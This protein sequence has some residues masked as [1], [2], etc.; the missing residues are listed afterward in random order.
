MSK[1]A[2]AAGVLP[3]SVLRCAYG[4]VLASILSGCNWDLLPS[5]T[6]AVRTPGQTPP[7]FTS[8]NSVAVAEG[9]MTG[10]YTATANDAEGDT[11]SF[12]VSGGADGD[13]FSIDTGNGVVSFRSPPDFE[14]PSDDNGDNT[15]VVDLEVDD[16]RNGR[17]SLTLS[18]RVD[19]ANDAPVFTSGTNATTPENVAYRYVASAFDPDQDPLTFSIAGGA[20]QNAFSIDPATGFVEFAINPDFDLPA[21][22]NGD[23]VY[24][25][26][27]LADD[28]NGGTASRMLRVTVTDI[29]ELELTIGFPTRAANIGGIP[30]TRISGIVDDL[31]DG[32]VDADDLVAVE[33]NGEMAAVSAGSPVVWTHDIAAAVPADQ[34]MLRATPADGLGHLASLSLQNDAVIIRPDLLALDT[35]DNRLL[36]ADG[37]GL[38]ALVQ[39]DLGNN[40]KSVLLDGTTGNGP[41][42]LFPEAAVLDDATDELV[43]VDSVQ[44][45]II[46]LDVNTGNRV[47][48]SGDSAGSGP[49]F[50]TPLA[51]A[52]DRDGNRAL[53]TDAGLEALISVNLATGERTIV[54]DAGIGIGP[55]LFFPTALVL[56]AAN[57]RALVADP[58]LEAIVAVDLANGNRT[59]VADATTGAI[60]DF[61]IAVYLDVSGSRLY[62]AD[63][64]L[65]ALITID[66]ATGSGTTI[67]DAATGSGP[68]FDFLR[69]LAVDESRNRVF[70]TDVGLNEILAID[71]ASGDR[72]PYGQTRTGTGPLISAATGAALSTQSSRMLV[73]TVDAGN[74]QLVWI[75]LNDG[76]RS[77]LADGVTG[78]GPV[79]GSISGPALDEPGN[80]S[81]VVDDTL[82]ALVAVDLGNGARSLVSGAG[83][84]SG[85]PLTNPVAVSL[86]GTSN[87]AFVVDRGLN[88]ILAIDLATGVRTLLSGAGAGIGPDFV[89]PEAIAYDGTRDRVLVADSALEALLAVDLVTGNR[90]VVADAAQGGGPVIPAPRAVAVDA[91]NDRAVVAGG[92][93]PLSIFAVD[94]A[95]GDR[96]ILTSNAA[97]GPAIVN[98][99]GVAVDAS[100]GRLFLVDADAGSLVVVDE[101]TGQRAV[102]SR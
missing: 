71:L 70:V 24:E 37:G 44:R 2:S 40:A 93:L 97:P 42:I 91:E 87:R 75:E 7:V 47:L 5:H 45:A 30:L 89:T 73:S 26:N 96:S 86:D 50:D 64:N 6:A 99:S 15:Y 78:S 94:L 101:E 83:A 65:Q 63:L 31:E 38:G 67:S 33:V 28:G 13:R 95:S 41:P 39:A 62:V 85:V 76:V 52:L 22:A 43:I 84:G 54:S 60:L 72:T 9:S 53:V 98:V 46:I 14:N 82:D 4:A 58:V 29:S 49:S 32:V 61:P 102:V 77:V 69:A 18:V 8:V 48:L 10:I 25:I 100:L 74:G 27:I 1:Q 17:D 90:T 21:D 23:N 92:V 55:P 68:S 51:I 12:R 59:V 35:N 57:N 56:D 80:R 19:D 36:V 16:G 88:V 3:A 11:L 81:F 20:D 79:L 66:L 34:F